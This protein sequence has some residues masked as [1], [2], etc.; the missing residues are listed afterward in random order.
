M[1]LINDMA[2]SVF[3]EGENGET[4]YFPNGILSKGRVVSDSNREKQ[5]RLFSLNSY[6]LLIPF[7]LFCMWYVDIKDPFTFIP[8]LVV[9]VIDFGFKKY[10]L[11]GLPVYVG[12][13]HSKKTLEESEEVYYP[14]IIKSFVAVGLIFMSL[15]LYFIFTSEVEGVGI[16][17]F[18][19][20]LGV[21]LLGVGL[22]MLRVNKSNKSHK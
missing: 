3:R 12:K 2:Q 5:I 16:A 9:G 17:F 4:I 8:I 13:L 11:R 21:L 22:F 18:P 6:R 1:G 7:L 19:V 14:S 20:F 10:L 15:G